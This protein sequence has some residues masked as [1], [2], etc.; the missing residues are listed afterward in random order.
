MAAGLADTA[1]F[2]LESRLRE[3]GARCASGPMAQ[4]FALRASRLVT[5]QNPAYSEAVARLTLEAI[6]A[7]HAAV[8]R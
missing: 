8:V 7:A 2:A 5:G 1:S 3:L 4:P 6:G